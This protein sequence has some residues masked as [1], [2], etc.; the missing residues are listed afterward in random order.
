[1]SLDLERARQMLSLASLRHREAIAAVQA[2]PFDLERCRA[3]KDALNDCHLL[4]EDCHDITG[5][6]R[7]VSA[8]A[9]LNQQQAL[10]AQGIAH[11]EAALAVQPLPKSPW[12]SP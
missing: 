9:E 2:R 5:D 1:M 11:L 6:P 8:I 4:L 12:A 7:L 3:A 10:L